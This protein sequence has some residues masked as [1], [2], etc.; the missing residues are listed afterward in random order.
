[1]NL[2]FFCLNQ[3]FNPKQ[4]YQPI[5]YEQEHH[6]SAKIQN[7]PSQ[8]KSTE[9][10]GIKTKTF[11]SNLEPN[12]K[13]TNSPL[14][15]ASP[16]Q[17]PM[18]LPPRENFVMPPGF[19]PTQKS[20]DVTQEPSPMKRNNYQKSF[21]NGY[22]QCNDN[23]SLNNNND[24]FNSKNIH[25]QHN[26]PSSPFSPQAPFMFQNMNFNEFQKLQMQLQQPPTNGEFNDVLDNV[27]NDSAGLSQISINNEKLRFL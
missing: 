2:Y 8:Q 9:T 23:I 22:Q 1:M 14:F 15:K 26:S 6:D 25:Y 13:S 17:I 10:N 3:G 18:P 7:H 4:I 20:I 16:P 21:Q 19:F 27:I 11:N 5:L 12:L 24:N